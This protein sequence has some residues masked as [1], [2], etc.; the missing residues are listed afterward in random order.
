MAAQMYK[1]LS[2]S[3]TRMKGILAVPFVYI[4]LMVGTAKLYV[5]ACATVGI[6]FFIDIVKHRGEI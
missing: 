6:C 4:A 5:H 3:W 1:W 2:I